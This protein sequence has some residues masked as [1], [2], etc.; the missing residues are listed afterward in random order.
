MKKNVDWWHLKN[1]DLG[2]HRATSGVA[3][4]AWLT[5][6]IATPTQARQNSRTPFTHVG[7]GEHRNGETT[8]GV[9]RVSDNGW[10][11]ISGYTLS[12]LH[13]CDLFLLSRCVACRELRLTVWGVIFSDR[14]YTEMKLYWML[15]GPITV[16]QSNENSESLW[17]LDW[18][19]FEKIP[20]HSEAKNIVPTW[21]R[22]KL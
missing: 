16:C 7:E 17:A 21:H 13:R 15:Q 2:R 18:L 4:H 6:L 20:H 14:Y 3:K 12:S 11:L 9:F 1:M 10:G 19:L 8:V 5:W 22:T